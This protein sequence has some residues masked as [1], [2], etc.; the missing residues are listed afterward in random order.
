MNG[1]IHNCS[2]PNEDDIHFRISEAQ[3]FQDV[4]RYIEF[5][6][7]M[8]KPRKL[9]FMAIDGVA[10][11]AKMNQQRGRRFRSAK[12]AEKKE[13][14]AKK[15][16]DVLPKEARFDSNCITPGTEFMNKLHQ[17]LKWFIAHKISTDELWKSV[18]VILSGHETPGEGEHKIMDY[19]RYERSQPHHDPNTRHCLYGLDADLIVLG[20]ASHE[21]HFS[22]LREEVKFLKSK[23]SESGCSRGG[24]GGEKGARASG[25]E[26]SGQSGP[27]A[28]KPSAQR[29]VNPDVITF[30]LLHLSLLRDYLDLEF[31]ELKH[32]LIT[33]AYDLEH[34]IDDWI[35]MGFLVGNDFIPHL[36]H[37]HINKNSLTLLYQAYVKVLP[38]LDGYLNEN[39]IL[40]LTRFEEFLKEVSKIDEENFAKV[41]T[42]LKHFE[43]KCTISNQGGKVRNNDEKKFVSYYDE[44]EAEIV[45]EL[46]EGDGKFSSFDKNGQGVS[47]SK[48]SRNVATVKI[49]TVFQLLE[50]SSPEDNEDIY[51]G[52]LIDDVKNIDHDP[53]ESDT[54]KTEFRL[55][56][57]AYYET[58]L[59]YE[60]V[61]ANVHR[62]QAECYIRA[63]QW[64]LHYYYNGCVSW[65]WFYPHHYA[66][67]ISDVKN[68]ASTVNVSFQMGKPFKPYE[69]LLAVLPA[70]S[71]Q[72]LPKSY[73][74]LV[75]DS[76]SPIIANYP[77]EFELDMYE[78]QQDWEAVVRIPFIDESALLK[79]ASECS[80][81]FSASEKERNKHGPHLKFTFNPDKS[82]VAVYQSPFPAIFPDI[83]K[84]R[85]VINTIDVDHYRID[86]RTITKG[87]LPG[88]KLPGRDSIH[89]PGFP[90]LSFV[91]F[92]ARLTKDKVRVF[93]TSSSNENI[94]LEI[95]SIDPIPSEP[96]ANIPFLG[97]KSSNENEGM[98]QLATR[99]LGTTIFVNWPHLIEARVETITDFTTAYF[100][101]KNTIKTSTTVL[102]FDDDNL[103]RETNVSSNRAI[104]STKLEQFELR[105]MMDQFDIVSKVY[106]DRKGISLGQTYALFVVSPL[107]GTKYIPTS[108]TVDTFNGPRTRSLL[109]LQKQW[110]NK[111]LYAPIQTVVSDV[112]VY[113]PGYES[114]YKTLEEMFTN[115]S[116]CFVLAPQYYGCSAEV[117]SLVSD[118]PTNA[119]PSLIR[120]KI[121]CHS[122]EP[123]LFEVRQ[124]EIDIMKNEYDTNYVLAQ[125]LGISGHVLSRFLG[126]IFIKK[127]GA[128]SG[129]GSNANIGLC[130]KFN[131]RN[132][133]I[134]GFSKKQGDT[135]MFSSKVQEMMEEYLD[136]FP[137]VIRKVAN[138]VNKN[139]FDVEDIFDPND[140][141]S[142]VLL[143]L[144]LYQIIPFFPELKHYKT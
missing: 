116:K 98:M 25:Q 42:D 139:T 31:S 124:R 104:R 38:N 101:D 78:K 46:I 89:F 119:D 29:T 132:E 90:T 9:F 97:S 20:L 96:T 6:F 82:Q 28:P 27:L 131:S 59:K 107:T 24:G 128:S 121:I 135:W 8:I 88:T 73:Q 48:P 30:H 66:P 141:K 123:D 77:T 92:S 43:E 55:H 13:E 22:L 99:Y 71:K 144:N 108:V 47:A 64:N 18:T 40:N 65:S 125:K 16:G 85:A 67:Y 133:E 122:S 137:N 15:K 127:G 54:F 58:K 143:T 12:D 91:K 2:H 62:E 87:I 118:D 44:S 50:S 23:K 117:I 60:T 45:G 130:L 17:G 4:F 1:I 51:E 115:G 26:K 140:T 142:Y 105:S 7:R 69:Q 56:K 86:P 21:P 68:F 113:D 32:T 19:I 79:A 83:V 111:P 80:L 109:A 84:S 52:D 81:L 61:D 126:S 39:G 114:K 138:Q 63:L 53:E 49:K 37:F 72:L 70:A 100:L 41:Y 76:R 34:V 94:I 35:L 95:K 36:P 10:P 3:I 129:Y 11:R 106:K 33:F 134:S 110:S 93:E 5:L 103:P 14:E 112:K 57:D 120:V 102:S 75:T 74:W 136:K